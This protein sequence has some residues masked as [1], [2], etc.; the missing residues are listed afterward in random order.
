MK[1][2]YFGY[3]FFYSCLEHI[4]DAGH[5]VLGLYTFETDNKYNFNEKVTSLAKS[6]GVPIKN[7]KVSVGDLTLLERQECELLVVAAYPYRIPIGSTVLRGVN[8]HPSLLPEGRGPWPLPHVI[9]MGLQEGGVS[10][11][12]LASK[13]DSGAVL[14]QRRFSVDTANENIETLSCKLQ[15]AAAPLLAGVLAQLDSYWLN[16]VTQGEGSYWPFPSDE[17]MMLDWNKGVMDIHRVVRAYGKMHS[18][19]EFDGKRWNVSDASVWQEEHR[20]EPGYV[21]LRTNREA[22]VAARDG[23]VCLRIFEEEV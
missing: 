10:I 21:V 12:K 3:D 19:A 6:R 5:E 16:A 1:I 2:A 18:T 11:H 8:V 23:Y 7:S 13:F 20:Y 9:L 15:L 22:L 17:D 14:A 4:L